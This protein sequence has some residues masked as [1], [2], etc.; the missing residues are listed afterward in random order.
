MAGP[1]KVASIQLNGKEFGGA[2]ILMLNLAPP[3]AAFQRVV[4]E[5]S[6][7]GVE[8]TIPFAIRSLALPYKLILR[9][10]NGKP[11]TVEGMIS[12][13]TLRG[14]F[15]FEIFDMYALVDV[16]M[17]PDGSGDVKRIDYRGGAQTVEAA[18]KWIDGGEQS[19]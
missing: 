12:V 4:F 9:Y 3:P 8:V 18:R 13:M 10:P 11:F 7:A 19:E 17:E 16:V 5:P 1:Y 14:Y 15:Y 6:P 2:E